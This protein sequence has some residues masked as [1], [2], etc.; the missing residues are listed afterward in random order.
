MPGYKFGDSE[1]FSYL[2]PDGDYIWQIIGV[3]FGV[4][5][6]TGPTN[7]SDNVGLK[8]AFYNGD[9]KAAQWTETLIFH[10]SL[11]WKIDTFLK[12]GNYKV[13]ADGKYS[14]T[15]RALRENEQVN[16]ESDD[17]LGL[18]GWCSVKEHTYNEKKNSRVDKWLTDREKLP[19]VQPPTAKDPW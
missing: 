1:N 15:G 4:Q 8:I 16:F 5:R 19:K 3:E 17:L 18:R 9:K 11:F 13:G 12:S 6:G 14:A 7:G 2:I 10:P